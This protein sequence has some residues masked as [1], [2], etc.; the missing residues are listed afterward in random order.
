MIENSAAYRVMIVDDES[1]LRT[2]I[3]H[4]CNW[5][6]YSIEIVAQ[7]SNGQEALELIDKARPHVVITDIV[8]PVMDGVEFTK[9]MRKQHPDIK[10]IVLSSY[11]EFDYVREVF[12][13]GVND[14]LLK[15][16]VSATE[17]IS[18]IQSLCGEMGTGPLTANPREFDAALKLGQ[19]LSAD[20][21]A[22]F[23]YDSQPWR[24]TFP[25]E[26]YRMVKAS[27]SILLSR[28]QYTQ[29]QIEQVLIGLAQDHLSGCNYACIF[30][31]NEC[32]VLVNYD[33]NQSGH[34]AV[35]LDAFT[36]NAM[37]SLSFIKFVLSQEFDSL[38]QLHAQHEWLT[39]CMGKLIYFPGQHCVGEHEI[40]RDTDKVLFDQ[41]QF[42]SSIRSLA[43]ADAAE[44]C[45]TLL[46]HIRAT[47]AYDEYSLKRLCQNIIYSAM[48]TLEQ[49]KQPLSELNS[50]KLKLF[51]RID[52][53]FDWNELETVYCEFMDNLKAVIRQADPQSKILHQIYEY[54]NQNYAGEISLSELAD[55]FHLNYSYL[56]TYFKQRT[57]ENLTSY[58]NRV[59]IDKAKELLR[60]PDLSVSHISQLTGFSDHNYFSK[61]FKK[62]TGMTPVEHRNHILAM[63]SGE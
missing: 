24:D 13:Y 26:H 20:T 36:R 35:F 3:M 6:E 45:Q 57:N 63:R 4:L 29:A 48:S 47:Q 21:N 9:L 11:S 1:I 62:V 53:A 44:Q 14:Y 31:K 27:T 22:N 38:G 32:L 37:K 34:V 40:K 46:D 12:K 19:Y 16:K 18:L 2:G 49:M 51:K 39:G 56:S 42:T 59:R 8:M 30:L 41:A 7:A 17:L 15:P 5:S 52:L 43:I 23:N 33:T 50:S 10:V 25:G 58:I 60:N 55:K 28:T 54:V 61:V